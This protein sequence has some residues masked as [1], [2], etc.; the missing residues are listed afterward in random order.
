MRAYISNCKSRSSLRAQRPRSCF[1]LL[2][3]PA[4][5]P[6]PWHL[7]APSTRALLGC[8]HTGSGSA[9]ASKNSE[10]LRLTKH[11]SCRLGQGSLARTWHVRA[12]VVSHGQWCRRHMSSPSRGPDCWLRR[13]FE[14]LPPN[15]CA[16]FYI[17]GSY[18]GS[19][20]IVQPYDPARCALPHI[21][22]C[23]I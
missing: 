13:T 8:S 14:Y 22:S 21:L 4:H 3:V 6:P 11:T 23:Q 10:A 1:P 12:G 9:V 17:K 5:N 16:Y 20:I 2:N 7:L 18:R 15:F 19:T